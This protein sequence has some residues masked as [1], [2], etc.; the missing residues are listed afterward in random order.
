MKKIRNQAFNRPEWLSRTTCI[1]LFAIVLAGC[2]SVPGSSPQLTTD[3]VSATDPAVD[4]PAVD[5]TEAREN[6]L[7]HADSEV[8][9]GG[10]VQSVE[11]RN[12]ETWIELVERPLNRSGQPQLGSLS[13]GR[14]I[15]V[16]PEFLDPVDYRDGTVVT[17][18][19]NLSGEHIGTIG[20]ASY[21]FPKVAV[22][23]H[24]RWRQVRATS[25]RHSHYRPYRGAFSAGIHLG[26][27]NSLSFGYKS[28]IFGHKGRG[29]RSHGHFS[30]RHS[31]GHHRIHK[32]NRVITNS[33][34]RNR[35]YR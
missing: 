30:N 5:I 26:S 35:L 1:S 21:N 32:R 33:S 7:A 31:H 8:H 2:A 12:D 34:F 25:N 20:S 27:R 23:D 16:V 3:S 18:V 15:A 14:F 4:T 9:W 24:Q 29:F 22:T 6:P 17:V 13:H 11:N 19:G 28:R 10:V